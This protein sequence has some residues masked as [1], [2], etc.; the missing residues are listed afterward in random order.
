MQSLKIDRALR[1]ATAYSITRTWIPEF[2]RSEVHERGD[3]GTVRRF[4]A[5]VEAPGSAFVEQQIEGRAR[6]AVDEHHSGLGGRQ[7]GR[8][9]VAG[10]VPDRNGDDAPVRE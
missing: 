8:I 6:A 5:Q 4:G 7:H 3:E 9:L 1:Q 2:R 10:D